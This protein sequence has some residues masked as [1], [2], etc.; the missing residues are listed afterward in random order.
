MQHVL[1][2]DGFLNEAN[3]PQ[4]AMGILAEYVR[5]NPAGKKLAADCQVLV[6][7]MRGMGTKE[8]AIMNVFKSLKSKDEFVKLLALWDSLDLNYE[9]S[10][11]HILGSIFKAFS[12]TG[13]AYEKNVSNRWNILSPT[14]KDIC[15]KAAFWNSKGGSSETEKYLKARKEW[16]AKN[17][18]MKETS[19]NYWLKEELDSSE[20]ADLNAI[21][22]KFGVKF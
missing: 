22:K 6:K 12:G 16:Y 9:Q 19:L 15:S 17:P 21:I 11:E 2:F 4:K 5:N 3:S 7:A 1:E 10:G 8:D 20:L 18:K 14:M 13:G